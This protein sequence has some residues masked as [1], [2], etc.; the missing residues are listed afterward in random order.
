MRVGRLKTIKLRGRSLFIDF[1]LD[2]AIPPIPFDSIDPLRMLLDIR[3]WEMNRTHWAVKD[4]DLSGAL[5]EA[6]LLPQGMVRPP[7]VEERPA[8]EPPQNQVNSVGAFV[9]AVLALTKE[10]RIQS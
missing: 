9:T 3:D 8:P 5:R 4:E 10:G 6:G 1:E 7:V 2:Q